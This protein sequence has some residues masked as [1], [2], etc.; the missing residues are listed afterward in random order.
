MACPLLPTVILPPYPLPLGDSPRPTVPCI[1]V[2]QPS[3]ASWSSGQAQARWDPG[4][5]AS[6]DH[7]PGTG[8]GHPR[9][10]LVLLPWDFTYWH[11]GRSLS[12]LTLSCRNRSLELSTTTP[13][14]LPVTKRKPTSKRR[15]WSKPWERSK[16][17][18]TGHRGL[19]WSHWSKCHPK[20][21]PGTWQ[22]KC[23]CLA[24]A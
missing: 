5:V 9:A 7:G 14:F 19:L 24:F 18:E 11:L 1:P 4:S 3:R 10:H 22:K 2:R 12:S 21:T 13:P 17:R 16:V 6:R 23:L 15:E 8:T 20:G